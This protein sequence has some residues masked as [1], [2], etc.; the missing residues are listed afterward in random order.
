MS[1]SCHARK[2][3]SQSLL[4]RERMKS[5]T[6]PM[7]C[8]LFLKFIYLLRGRIREREIL[9]LLAYPSN[10]RNSQTAASEARSRSFFQVPDMRS[11]PDTE[12]CCFSRPSTESDHDINLCHKMLALQGEGLACCTT[13]LALIPGI[14]Q[15]R[16]TVRMHFPFRQE[17]EI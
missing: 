11:G 7:P 5:Q 9:H 2:E 17:L 13:T 10:G 14:P 4:N 8:F 1:E 3:G 12:L 15:T 6:N 16:N